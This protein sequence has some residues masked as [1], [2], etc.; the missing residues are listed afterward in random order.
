MSPVLA[1]IQ[2]SPTPYSAA[3]VSTPLPQPRPPLVLVVDDDVMARR[4]VARLLS[5]CAFVRAAATLAQARQSL[6]QAP[7]AALVIELEL[8]GGRALQLIEQVR[9]CHR[10]LPVLVVSSTDNV[11]MVSRASGLGA[12][13]VSKR[14]SADT[15]ATC[16]T[17][18]VSQALH[19]SNKREA[20]VARVCNRAPLTPAEKE[21]LRLYTRLGE[22]RLLASELGIAETSVRSRVRGICRKLDI[23][24]LHDVF[25]LMV[26][27]T[28]V[29][30]G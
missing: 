17:T 1:R 11:V 8:D 13:F 22:R 27:E 16:V 26:E 2:P 10:A 6:Q 15:L 19:R 25:R 14:A 9:K 5:P 29:G 18:L 24:R 12:A 3:G 4:R 23:E 28:M 7:I 21:A 20:L 30:C